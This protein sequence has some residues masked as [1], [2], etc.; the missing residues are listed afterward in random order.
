MQLA[1]FNHNTFVLGQAAMMVNEGLPHFLV[2][3]VRAT[4]DL[5]KDTVGILG[6]AFK[7]DSDDART[8]LAYKLRKIL[9]L[10]AKRVLCTDPFVEDSSFVPLATVLRESDV[11]FLGAPHSAYGRIRTRKPLV[12]CWDFLP[13]RRP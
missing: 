6:M 4:R 12:D 5:S 11:L 1:A 9:S 10:R 8:S 3:Q 2:E 7:G 13:R